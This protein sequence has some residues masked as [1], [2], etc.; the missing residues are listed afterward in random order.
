MAPN[1]LGSME[2]SRIWVLAASIAGLAQAAQAPAFEVASIRRGQRGEGLRMSPGEIA[3]VTPDGVTLRG[4][5]LKAAIRWAYHVFEYQVT[6]P[7]WIGTERYDIAAK[8]AGAVSAEQLRLMMQRLLAERFKL[9]VHRE[10]K[11]LPAF[12]V[13]LG[14]NG[15]KF[16]E[17]KEDGE[18]KVQPDPLRFTVTVSRMPT[19]QVVEILSNVLRAPVV[20]R[21]GLKGKYDVTV[22]LQ[23]YL[24]EPGANSSTFDMTST[25]IMAFQEELGLKLE[26]K[27]LPIDLVVVDHA[28]KAPTEN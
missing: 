6:G 15:P 2:I 13:T 27:K 3:V 21:T 19:S 18:A 12:L 28:E 9:T 22:P 17:S 26:S 16:H 25:I 10:T 20:D 8:A 5:N 24:P 1:V 4:V 7:D 23:K 11:E 14:K